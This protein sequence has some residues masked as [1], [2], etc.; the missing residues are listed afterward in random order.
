MTTFNIHIHQHP[1]NIHFSSPST[2][3]TA[4][5][6]TCGASSCSRAAWSS[7]ASGEWISRGCWSHPNSLAATPGL[8]G[9]DK[10]RGL[11]IDTLWLFKKA[12]ESGPFIDGLPKMV[13]FHGYVSLPEVF[14]IY[15]IPFSFVW[16]EDENKHLQLYWRLLICRVKTYFFLNIKDSPEKSRGLIASTQSFH[17][18]SSDDSGETIVDT[19]QELVGHTALAGA[20]PMK[21]A[22][23][24]RVNPIS[25]ISRNP[26][27]K[28]VVSSPIEKIWG[29][30]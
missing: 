7:G 9:L 30:V 16:R 26:R 23:F 18:A 6:S 5:F 12:M 8:P 11:G 15:I 3:T 28:V 24:H 19:M 29:G 17:P 1:F 25:S 14:I 22:G 20:I 13:V 21:N 10:V 27:S 4:P 2:I